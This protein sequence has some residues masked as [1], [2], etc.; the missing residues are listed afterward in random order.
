M[1][2]GA[3]AGSR[4]EQTPGP[5]QVAAPF[6]REETQRGLGAGGGHSGRLHARN[7]FLGADLDPLPAPGLDDGPLMVRRDDAALVPALYGAGVSVPEQ[8][9]KRPDAAKLLD[10][11]PGG[12][13]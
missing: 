9:G 13:S 11:R 5:R 7:E 6:F 3:R 1:D 10:D 8:A 2:K 4:G 12:K